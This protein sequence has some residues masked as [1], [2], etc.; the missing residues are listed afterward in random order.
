MTRTADRNWRKRW[1]VDGAACSAT[2]ASGLRVRFRLDDGQRPPVGSLC[3]DE[4]GR[5]Y[6]GVPESIPAD[7][8]V[9]S[10]PRLMREAGD[11]YAAHLKKRS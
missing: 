8:P 6:L 3:F 7:L 10:L 9:E 2:H 4:T 11:V 5:V 1:R